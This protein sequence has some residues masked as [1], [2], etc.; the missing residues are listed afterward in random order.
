MTRP[1]FT[2][3]AEADVDHAIRWHEAERP[4]RGTKLIES[5]DAAIELIEHQSAAF[6]EGALGFQ[7]VVLR[8]FPYRLYF[9]AEGE[10]L[11]VHA[12][13]HTALNPSRLLTRLQNS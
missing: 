1:L 11:V 10:Q 8:R 2:V 9:R 7:S 12:L 13:F 3:N 4:G 5:L 6:P